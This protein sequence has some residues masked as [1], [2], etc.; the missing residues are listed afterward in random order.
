M[1]GFAS[2]ILSTMRPFTDDVAGTRYQHHH[3]LVKA[4]PQAQA[5]VLACDELLI[6]RVT[7]IE[8]L[9]GLSP[10]EHFV[11]RQLLNSFSVMELNEQV[12]V[13]AVLIR[14]QYRRM[15]LPDAIIYATAQV[16]GLVLVTR[17]TRDFS[18]EMPGVRI[19]YA[20]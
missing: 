15:K 8:A 5:E 13:Q 11:V 1:S 19:P 2:G 17:N 4:V 7:W 12:A 10:Q 9:I 20:I 14:Q 6:S 3:R 16:R 18:E